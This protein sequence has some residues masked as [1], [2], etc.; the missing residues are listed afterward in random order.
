MNQAIGKQ[1]VIHVLLAVQ[2]DQPAYIQHTTNYI[3]GGFKSGN[4]QK[5]KPLTSLAL[6][7][8]ICELFLFTI[9]FFDFSKTGKE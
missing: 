3:K 1:K 7:C 8:T 6:L 9:N 4:T 5:Q 2:I